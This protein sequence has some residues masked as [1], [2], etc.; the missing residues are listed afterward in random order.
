VFTGLTSVGEVR[1]Y[2]EPPRLV[3]IARRVEAAR[4]LPDVSPGLPWFA[5]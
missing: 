1:V 5:K 3:A 2:K 4:Q